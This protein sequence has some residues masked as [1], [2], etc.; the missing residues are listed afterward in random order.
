M[1]IKDKVSARNF[2]VDTVDEGTVNFLNTR[3]SEVMSLGPDAT[4]NVCRLLRHYLMSTFGLEYFT[5]IDALIKNK[6]IANTDE[7]RDHISKWIDDDVMEAIDLICETDIFDD[8]KSISALA[9]V[10][11]ALY[12]SLD[13]ITE[14]SVED[15]IDYVLDI[16][17]QLN[18]MIKYSPRTPWFSKYSFKH[19][20]RGKSE[21]INVHL[22]DKKISV[23]YRMDMRPWVT[24]K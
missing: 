24:T 3:F 14:E 1:A 17:Y 23:S 2:L 6:L 21:R 15:D 8:P 12:G 19:E 4:T 20:E 7:D 18:D 10:M 22:S 16:P 13:A 11:V 9:D 5:K